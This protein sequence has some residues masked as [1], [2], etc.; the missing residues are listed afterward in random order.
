[1]RRKKTDA[2]LIETHNANYSIIIKDRDSTI[3]SARYSDILV[4]SLKFAIY[5]KHWG[6]LLTCVVLIHDNAHNAAQ[7]IKRLKSEVIRYT[8]VSPDLAPFRLS[9]CLA[10]ERSHYGAIKSPQ[11]KSCREQCMHDLLWECTLN[12][13]EN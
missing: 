6:Q 8:P 7:T 9:S 1:M 12:P 2:E 4:D 10:H 3:N 5:S 11:T 13:L